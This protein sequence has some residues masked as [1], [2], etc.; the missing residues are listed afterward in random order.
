MEKKVLSKDE[1]LSK[2]DELLAAYNTT[3][4]KSKK[5]A[6]LAKK[7]KK[8]LGI[9]KDEGRAVLKYARISSR[10]VKIVLDLIKGKG[11]DE[12]YGIVKYTPKAA[13]EVIYKLL[14]SAEANAANNNGL[15]RDELYVAEAYAN[16][17]PTLK[18]IMPRAQG[19]ANRIRKRTSHITLVLKEKK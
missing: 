6:L 1:L 4:R 2:K 9:G 19:R 16:Q 11:I 5:P 3:H 15:D 7:E 17:G 8:A 13:S 10:K 18:R 12:A 14:K